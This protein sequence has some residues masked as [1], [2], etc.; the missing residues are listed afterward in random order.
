MWVRN[1]KI[2]IVSVESS[3]WTSAPSADLPSAPRMESVLY[4]E[5]RWKSEWF[6]RHFFHN[7]AKVSTKAHNRMWNVYSIIII[8]ANWASSRVVSKVPEPHDWINCWVLHG[9]N[10]NRA[11][12]R[13]AKTPCCDF[14]LY[15][16]CKS[17]F[18]ILNSWKSLAGGLFDNIF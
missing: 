2:S 1:R 6:C 8:E 18:S 13:I 16:H 9:R 5:F 17:M 12:V 15:L 11:L 4:S 14:I 3:S 10:H 7:T